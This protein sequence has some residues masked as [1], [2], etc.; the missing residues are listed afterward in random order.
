MRDMGA[1]KPPTKHRQPAPSKSTRYL[2]QCSQIMSRP[3]KRP[4][5]PPMPYIEASP[6]H[7][8]LARDSDSDLAAPKNYLTTMRSS[9]P[10]N[11][12]F[13]GPG[14]PKAPKL[15]RAVLRKVRARIKAAAY[16]GAKGRDVAEL[17]RRYDK[18]GSGHLSPDEVRKALRRTMKIPP[19]DI[20]DVQ[21][22]SLCNLLDTDQSGSVDIAELL[23]FIGP[24]PGSKRAH[25][26]EA[27]EKP[28]QWEPYEDDPR[29]KKTRD[30]LEA[31]NERNTARRRSHLLAAEPGTYSGT[32]LV[33]QTSRGPTPR[34]VYAGVEG[35]PRG[36]GA[37]L[38]TDA[39]V[40]LANEQLAAARATAEA[41]WQTA[42]LERESSK[43]RVGAGQ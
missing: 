14:T 42:V 5:A 11:V 40:S 4:A 20:A 19:R 1:P 2:R 7:A 43:G 6:R 10:R 30:D 9:S 27:A 23:E 36:G 33:H 24:E 12:A 25:L 8:A 22:Q 18:D 35:G 28:V 32:H 15:G 38:N 34:H 13:T 41:G 16:T 26:K 39:I 29:T 21:V 37:A 31:L 17:F 3:P